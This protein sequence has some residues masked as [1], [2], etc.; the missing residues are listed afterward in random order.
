MALGE[1]EDDG[2]VV[3]A[4]PF[5]NSVQNALAIR[6]LAVA[7]LSLK[8]SQLGTDLNFNSEST[9]NVLRR[10]FSLPRLLYFVQGF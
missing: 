4:P 1:G 10:I 6:K 9:F 3:A 8:G 7:S 2:S 5:G